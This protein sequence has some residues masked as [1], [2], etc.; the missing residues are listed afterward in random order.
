LWADTSEVGDAVVPVGGTTG[1]SLVK[2]SDGDYDSEWATL[3]I[4]A[5]P[6]G[7]ADD[8]VALD[9]AGAFKASVPRSVL[10][11]NGL[12]TIQQWKSGE[13]YGLPFVA[14]T[15]TAPGAGAL[16]CYPVV[17]SNTVTVDEI[18]AEVVT[19]GATSVLRAGIYAHDNTTRLPGELIVDAGTAAASS[20]GLK[21]IAISETLTPGIYWLAVVRQGADSV[22]FRTTATTGGFIPWLSPGP[23]LISGGTRN[24]YPRA[25]AAVT[26]ALPDPFGS[27]IYSSFT[28]VVQLKVA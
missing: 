25:N 26:G 28:P 23:A 27:V 24:A 21:S 7:S 19:A 20:P 8:L 11:A 2:A 18:T 5:V 10:E 12:L 4:P 17:V 16:T 1:Q 15:A 9:G 22:A 3:D 6:A 13:Y 14:T